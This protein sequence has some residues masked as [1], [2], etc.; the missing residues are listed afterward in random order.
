[1]VSK[2]VKIHT[3]Q[4]ARRENIINEREFVKLSKRVLKKKK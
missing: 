3:L 2:L 1:M 4:K